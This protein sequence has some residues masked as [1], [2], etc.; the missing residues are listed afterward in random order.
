M[1][2]GR[3]KIG[4]EIVWMRISDLFSDQKCILANPEDCSIKIYIG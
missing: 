3:P 1:K 2:K 4:E